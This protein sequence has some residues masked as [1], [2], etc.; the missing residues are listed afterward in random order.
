MRLEELIRKNGLTTAKKTSE[1]EQIAELKQK[2][3]EL[4]STVE[5]LRTGENTGNEEEE[6]H[7]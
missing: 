1:A 2:V 4:E 7:G 3:A 5:A 6:Q